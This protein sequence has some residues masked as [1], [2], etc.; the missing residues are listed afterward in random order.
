[1]PE[2]LAPVR[3]VLRVLV[4]LA[5]LLAPAAPAAAQEF[6]VSFGGD[7]NFS[8]SYTPPVPDRIVKA[9]ILPLT[10]A[11]DALRPFWAGAHLNI[12]N[13]ETVVSDRDGP[14]PPGKQFVFRSHPDSFRHLMDL[15]VNGFALANNHANDHGRQGM[16]DTLA[17]FRGEARR[18]PGPLLFAG[19]GEGAAAFAPAVADIAGVR[20]AF[21]SASFGSGSFGPEQGQT[22]MAYLSVPSHYAAVLQGLADAR[23]D[24][25]ILA[26]HHGTENVLTLDPGQRALFRRGL[27]EAGVNLVLG[28]H[29]HVVR[30][31]EADPAQGQAVF[32]SLGNLLFV[33][34]AEKDSG[35]PGGD[36]GL[37]GRAVFQRDR[38]GGGWRISALEAVPL[39][40][41]HRV[42]RLMVPARV[43]PT[44]ARLN[45]LSD[46][47]VGSAA[48]VRFA[49]GLPEAQTGPACFAPPWGPAARRMCCAVAPSGTPDCD[50]PDPM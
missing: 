47:S 37:L 9:G 22:G 2:P 11:T 14:G 8:R 24:L 10:D 32:Y 4:L 44:L 39:Q 6:V 29:P 21:A 7:V 42:P 50:L 40:G 43:G 33:G 48:A 49:V 41:V 46:L 5:G 38:P 12:I 26:L 23:A 27:D 36:F 35:P 18:R 31:V 28:H 34:G 45:R 3:A 30:A 20:V 16:A 17:F 1:M 13:V 19:I 15:G 25:R